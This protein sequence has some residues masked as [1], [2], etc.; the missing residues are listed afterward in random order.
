MERPRKISGGEITVT[1][2]AR[3]MHVSG[4]MII[5]CVITT[6]GSLTGCQIIKGLPH[7][8]E[9]AL[10]TMSKWRYSPVLYQ[11]RP[12]NV[13]YIFNIKVVLPGG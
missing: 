9:A 11:G 13:S 5:K 4:L 2:E 6:G 3:A 10:A 1:P 12:V 7:M 8:N